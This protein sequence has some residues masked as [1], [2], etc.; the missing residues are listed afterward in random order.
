MSKIWQDLEKLS[1]AYSTMCNVAL[2]PL[3]YWLKNP[4]GP[5][6]PPLHA[7]RFNVR[8]CFSRKIFATPAIATFGAA[9]S[10]LYAFLFRISRVL[11]SLLCI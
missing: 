3:V 4:A 1:W 2:G 5:Q 11:A 8:W 7:S 6:D 9:H 10:R